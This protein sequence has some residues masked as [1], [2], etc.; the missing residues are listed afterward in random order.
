MSI[1]FK[2]KVSS[3]VATPQTTVAPRLPSGTRLNS[4]GTLLLTST[5]LPSLDNFI[6]GGLPIGSLLLLYEDPTGNLSDS[7]VRCFLSE[8]IYNKQDLCVISMRNDP[9]E[10]LPVKEETI[11]IEQTEQ[12]KMKIAWRYENLS[13]LETT[14]HFH[15]DLQSSKSIASEFLDH[16]TIHRL[17][18]NDYENSQS[19]LSFRFY[20]LDRIRKLIGENYSSQ[21]TEKRIVRLAL[22]SF[23]SSL[24]DTENSNHFDEMFSFLYHL[25]V[26]LRTS[27]A[28]CVITLNERSKSLENL[29]D[30]V[31]NLKLSDVHH[32]DY[33]GFC[34]LI[35]LPRL[36]T[37]QAFVPDTW[38]IGI[39]LIKHRRNL[40]FEKYSIPPDLSE[41]ASRDEKNKSTN[42]CST[43]KQFDF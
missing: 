7:I 42:S 10:N 1:T 29:A 6:G 12:E 32:G 41:D 36:N 4:T 17:N 39:K 3:S 28:T 31:V 21:Q 40:L 35:K 22:P 26:L 19:K 11:S 37:I 27:L 43:S 18:W 38:D 34:Q 30:L 23:S 2:K 16:I 33:V 13:Q 24:F 9:C 14:S 15:Y 25:R 5:G 8:G 20:L